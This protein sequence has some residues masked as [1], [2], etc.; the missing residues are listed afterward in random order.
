MRTTADTVN[1][2]LTA[3]C[4]RHERSG[5]SFAALMLDVDHFK[6]IND[7]FG[8]P[9]GDEVLCALV[10]T[11]QATLRAADTVARWGGEEFLLLLPEADIGTALLSADRVRA[12]LAATRVVISGGASIDFT[13]SIGV[14]VPT[15][16]DPKELLRRSDMALYEAKAAGRNQVLPAA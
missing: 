3:E 9:A 1:A 6:A 14:A 13:V 2:L 8:H 5:Q 12:A 11:C 7:Q 4:N 16:N 10:R 15:G